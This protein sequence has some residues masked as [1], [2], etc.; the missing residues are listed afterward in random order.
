M[1]KQPIDYLE[2]SQE[3]FDCVEKVKEQKN[4]IKSLNINAQEK[5]SRIVM[6]DRIIRELQTTAYLL[7]SR[8]EQYIRDW[9]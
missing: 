3:Y 7:K 8:G 5:H 2:W 1:D 4:K 6:L 9:R